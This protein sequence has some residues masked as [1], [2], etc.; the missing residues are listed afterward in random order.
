[1]ADDT[2]TSPDAP[3]FRYTARL[4]NEI[5]ARWQDRWDAEHTFWAPNPSGLLSEGAAAAEGRPKLYVLDMF[6]YPSGDGLHVGHP[7]GYIGT[8]VYARFMRMQGHNVLHAMGYDAFGLPAE[9]YAVEH[10]RHPRETTDTN[11]ATMRRQLRALGLGH[12]A[13]RS[14]ATTDPQYY[15]WTQWIFLRIFDSWFDD[16][17]QR[18]RPIAE[19]IAELESGA[20][21][22]ESDANPDG[23]AWSDLDASMRRAVVDLSLIHI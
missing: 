3:S 4:A 19:L 12:D 2:P 17:R 7:V 14:V 18:A 23:P 10:G 6:P 8:D 9:Q 13:R 5:E 21:A 15:R 16:E 20:R 1:M 11:V 22:A